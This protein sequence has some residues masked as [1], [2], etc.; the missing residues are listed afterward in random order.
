ML[1]GLQVTFSYRRGEYTFLFS[2]KEIRD[3]AVGV[4]RKLFQKTLGAPIHVRTHPKPMNTVS[5]FIAVSKS[6]EQGTQREKSSKRTSHQTNQVNKVYDSNFRN[7]NN[8]D[9]ASLTGYGEF[10]NLCNQYYSISIDNDEKREN[11]KDTVINHFYPFVAQSVVIGGRVITA[12]TPSHRYV[13]DNGPLI[14]TVVDYMAILQQPSSLSTQKTIIKI[15]QDTLIKPV[16]GSS[17]GDDTKLEDEES[18]DEESEDEESEGVEIPSGL[19]LLGRLLTGTLVYCY[20]VVTQGNTSPIAENASLAPYWAAYCDHLVE[21]ATHKNSILPGLKATYPEIYGELK[22]QFKDVPDFDKVISCVIL[23]FLTQGQTTPSSKE[24]AKSCGVI[25]LLTTVLFISEAARNPVSFMTSKMMM[26][27]IFNKITYGKTNKPFTL[28]N[29]LWHPELLSCENDDERKQL[30][31]DRPELQKKGG[32]A[33]M[34]HCGSYADEFRNMDWT[35]DNTWEAELNREMTHARNKDAKILIRWLHHVMKLFSPDITTQLVRNDEMD[36]V[37]G[38]EKCPDLALRDEAKKHFLE[39]AR[40][41]FEKS[42][43]VSNSLGGVNCPESSDVTSA[44][45]AALGNGL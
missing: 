36:Q 1:T 34:S 20:L 5:D 10:S 11:V 6:L 25:P 40:G 26:E 37:R 4:M 33:S 13:Y 21:Y 45:S 19:Q 12:L 38:K 44:S 17:S 31:K 39:R 7:A 23:N 42:L 32:K 14:R 41:F 35:D 2:G 22:R 27:F 18:E 16:I 3:V 43:S 15:V 24:F 9:T 28:K 30:N 29:T 8:S